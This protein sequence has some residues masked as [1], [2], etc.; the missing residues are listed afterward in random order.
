MKKLK[1]ALIIIGFVGC[2]FSYLLILQTPSWN[3]PK[4]PVIKAITPHKQ[5]SIK[6]PEV[7]YSSPVR[8]KIPKINIDAAI[9]HMGLTPE[10]DM[11]EPAKLRDVGWYKF[12]SHPGNKG[13]AVIAGHYSLSK[14]ASIFDKLHT[15]SRDDVVY[16]EDE[17]GAI[18]TFTVR[19][20]KT[21]NKDAAA[22]EI[23]SSSDEKAHLNLITCAGTWQKA[24]RTYSDRLVVFTDR[25]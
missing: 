20:L 1:I 5:E 16:V 13:S 9:E 2:M 22:P 15:L 14:D 17:E 21:Y 7:N 4:S 8:L 11:Q 19:E 18:A 10:G 25:K 24:Q 3:E 6:Q 12:G 23:F